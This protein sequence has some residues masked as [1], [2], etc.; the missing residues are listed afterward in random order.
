VRFS[1]R[2]AKP[3]LAVALG[4][5]L[6]CV[7]G[8]IL[9][10]AFDLVDRV[11][12]FPRSLYLATDDPELTYVLRPGVEVVAWG[13]RVSINEHGMRGPSIEVDAPPGTHRILLIGDSVTFGSRL[14]WDQTLPALLAARLEERSGESYEVLN[15]GV[16]G[17]NTQGEL[18]F[19]RQ[20]GL[21]LEPG[22]VVVVYN[23]NDIDHLPVM[24]SRGMLTL[25]RSQRVATSSIRNWS[26]LYLLVHWAILNLTGDDPL[27][28]LRRAPKPPPGEF[29][30]LGVH[31]SR[32]RKAYY[33][34]PTDERWRV[35]VDSLRD[36]KRVTDERAI[37]LLVAIVPDGDQIGVSDPDLVP[38][39]KLGDLCRRLSLDCVDL[40]PAF[41]AAAGRPL[42]LD[43]MHPNAEGHRLIP[44]ALAARLLEEIPG[45][46][47]PPL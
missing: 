43:I 26:E 1:G 20:R 30:P 39:Q 28:E 34:D 35:M 12:G 24:G 16:D 4:V 36:I 45:G 22:T 19:L 41:A 9:A 40:H 21:A 29:H 27:L 44:D 2:L 5:L 23:L 37:R 15:G 10:R 14:E 6:A 13:I 8:E 3:L 46:E 7:A 18:A 33:R 42:F 32:L 47:P 38:Q 11:N 25:D 31:L 17:Y